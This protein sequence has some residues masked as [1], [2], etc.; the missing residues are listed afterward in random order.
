MSFFAGI[1]SK[2]TRLQKRCHDFL[3]RFRT[4]DARPQAEHIHI[5][6]LHTLVGRGPAPQGAGPLSLMSS[7]HPESTPLHRLAGRE[8]WRPRCFPHPPSAAQQDAADSSSHPR[9]A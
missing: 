6:V 9:V 7:D 4:N 8:A 5:V 3:R 1:I 2:K